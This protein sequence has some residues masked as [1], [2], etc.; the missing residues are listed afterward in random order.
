MSYYQEKVNILKEE[1]RTKKEQMEFETSEKR[2]AILEEEV[3]N[4]E[5]SIEELEKNYV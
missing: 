3:Y 1:V 4:T 2:L 5:Q